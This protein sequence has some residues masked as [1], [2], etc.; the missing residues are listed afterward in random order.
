MPRSVRRGGDR[1]F[2]MIEVIVAIALIS[3]IMAAL[4]TYFV[5]TLKV[6][7]RQAQ[8]QT[9][10]P[11]LGKCWVAADGTCGADSSRP[12]EMVRLVVGVTWAEPSCPGNFCVRA[13]TALFNNNPTDPVFG[14]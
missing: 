9:A 8:I 3:T 12:V 6:S 4:G 7:R 5:G 10:E 11:V 13:G 14:P 1:G 2:T